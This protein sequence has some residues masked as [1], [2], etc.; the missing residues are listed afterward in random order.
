MKHNSLV[1]TIFISMGISST[2]FC[3]ETSSSASSSLVNWTQN[4]LYNIYQGMIDSI[5][6]LISIPS[7]IV[8]TVSTWS[9]QQKMVMT[10][11]TIASLLAVYKKEVIK[12]WL[13][14]MIERLITTEEEYKFMKTLNIEQIPY[15]EAER[16]SQE[17]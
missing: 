17:E 12:R 11:A 9:D 15:E 6:G 10:T 2:N 1:L 5:T 14:D 13:Q 16:R 4:T 7:S 8:D 3:S